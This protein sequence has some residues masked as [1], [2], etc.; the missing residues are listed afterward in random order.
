MKGIELLKD[1]A[2]DLVKAFKKYA[3]SKEDGKITRIEI[4]EMLPRFAAVGKDLLKYPELLD[5]LKDIDS[6]ERK[7]LLDHIIEL[8]IVTDKAEIVMINLLEIV[9]AEILIYHNNVIP[10]INVFKK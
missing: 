8:D 2:T 10:I 9:E 1:L 4:I 6:S 3:E 7:E 5:E